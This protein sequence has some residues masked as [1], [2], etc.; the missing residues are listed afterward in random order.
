PAP[1]GPDGRG[2]GTAARRSSLPVRGIRRPAAAAPPRAS[3]GRA[4]LLGAVR[5]DPGTGA[6]VYPPGDRPLSLLP[7]GGSRYPD[8]LGS[9]RGRGAA[10]TLGTCWGGSA[11]RG[12]HPLVGP[13]DARLPGGVAGPT[14]RLVRSIPEVGRP[15]GRLQ[16]GLALPGD[17]PT[18][19]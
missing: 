12:S 8:R 14:L 11:D 6:L 1:T 19:R 5:P 17:G 4:R 3:R 16:P 9:D 13:G 18:A 15:G 10:G 7:L 2:R